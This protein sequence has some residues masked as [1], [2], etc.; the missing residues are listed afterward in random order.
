MKIIINLV[1]A[2]L[3]LPVVFVKNILGEGDIKGRLFPGAY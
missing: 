1:T 2:T 3:V